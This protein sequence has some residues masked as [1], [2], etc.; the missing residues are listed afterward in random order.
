MRGFTK[1]AEVS[2][3]SLRRW[4]GEGSRAVSGPLTSV[5]SGLSRS[6]ADTPPCRS[7]YIAARTAQIPM[8]IVQ[9]GEIGRSARKRKV[10]E[11]WPDS[12]PLAGI[13]ATTAAT[14]AKP[15]D[16]A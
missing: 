7:G 5:T 11:S 10:Q 8:L 9:A 2:P 16:N 3:K 1:P 13:D 14:A 15:P 12:D 4:T 6:L